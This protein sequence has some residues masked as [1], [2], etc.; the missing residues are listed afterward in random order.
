MNAIIAA[1]IN[2]AVIDSNNSANTVG[3][4]SFYGCPVIDGLSGGISRRY[5][6]KRFVRVEG[7]EINALQGAFIVEGS[8]VECRGVEVLTARVA[9]VRMVRSSRT[10]RT[11]CPA[12]IEAGWVPGFR[13]DQIPAP[14]ALQGLDRFVVFPVDSTGHSDWKAEVVETSAWTEA[15]AAW[16]AWRQQEGPLT[17]S[18]EG[19]W[20]FARNHTR[21][22]RH[23]GWWT[24]R[25]VADLLRHAEDAVLEDH[26]DEGMIFWSASRNVCGWASSNIFDTSSGEVAN[27]WPLGLRQMGEGFSRD[28]LT[29]KSLQIIDN[30]LHW[31]FVDDE[32][33]GLYVNCHDYF[34]WN[35]SPR[36]PFSDR[37]WLGEVSA[38][39]EL[40]RPRGFES[41]KELE[42][43][44]DLTA[45]DEEY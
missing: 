24:A 45:D 44:V 39:M 5:E 3:E 41:A 17:S 19:V 4:P 6:G 37:E 16:E 28:G 43:A 21:R 18:E 40:Q 13:A 7:I 10:G 23:S 31:K 34:I 38:A 14:K 22:H 15:V 35:G 1:S 9:E 32:G 20:R 25:E 8:G 36:P 27:V 12:L 29:V 26:G 11:S 30:K 42:D 2:S 33:N